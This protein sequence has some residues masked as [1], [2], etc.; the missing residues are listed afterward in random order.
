LCGTPVG[1]GVLSKSAC[2]LFYMLGSLLLC[3]QRISGILCTKIMI[4]FIFTKKFWN[5]SFQYRF[6]CWRLQWLQLQWAFIRET[7]F[8][9]ERNDVSLWAKR[10]IATIKCTIC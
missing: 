5:F 2:V 3:K 7:T 6:G 9:C 4:Y 1:A 8:L 10:R